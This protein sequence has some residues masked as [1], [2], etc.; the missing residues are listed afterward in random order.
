MVAPLWETE[1][2]VAVE[3]L[4][5][6][7]GTAGRW[8]CHLLSWRISSGA[9]LE[10]KREGQGGNKSP[11]VGSLGVTQREPR[12]EPPGSYLQRLVRGPCPLRK[13]QEGL[14]VVGAQGLGGWQGAQQTGME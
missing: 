12:M 9:A 7:A 2:Y 4:R 13:L 6:L 3:A 11:R 8:W 14:D 5:F 10:F 1:G